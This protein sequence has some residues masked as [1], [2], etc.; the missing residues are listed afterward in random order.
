MLQSYWENLSERERRLLAVLGLVA[1]L[2]VVALPVWLLNTAIGRLSRENDELTQA[3]ANLSQARPQLDAQRAERAQAR[4][5]YISRAPTLGAFLEARAGEHEGLSI[6]DVQPEPE[7]EAGDFRVRHTRARIQGTGL[8]AAIRMLTDIE[9]SRYPVALE[10]IHVDHLQA[11]DRY[12]F[13]LG[14]LAF[15][16]PEEEGPADAGAGD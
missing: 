12:N 11:G 9:N 2:I 1:A 14:L 16:A 10:R 4:L 8:E 5:R 7:R 6:S 15:D 3:L 13:Q